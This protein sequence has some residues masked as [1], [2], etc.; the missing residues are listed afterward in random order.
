MYKCIFC[1]EKLYYGDCIKCKIFYSCNFDDSIDKIFFDFNKE[2]CLTLDNIM[3]SIFIEYPEKNTYLLG[4]YN[5]DDGQKILYN[6]GKIDVNPKNAED[7]IK[8]Y[9][10]LELFI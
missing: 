8:R 6:F 10:N 4:K 3:F 7:F 5:E 9:F 1:N 2:L